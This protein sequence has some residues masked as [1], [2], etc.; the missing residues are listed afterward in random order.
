MYFLS[1]EAIMITAR[2]RK[3]GLPL[4]PSDENIQKKKEYVL[5]EIKP[6]AA[7]Q[8]KEKNEQIR[9]S[10]GRR[11]RLPGDIIGKDESK[12][13]GVGCIFRGFEPGKTARARIKAGC[14]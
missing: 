14:R 2:R 11:V 8:N 5:F 9:K 1:A 13:L 12:A 10:P 7:P 3:D 6:S 4:C